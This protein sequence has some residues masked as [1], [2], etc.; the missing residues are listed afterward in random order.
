MVW[1]QWFFRLA[2]DNQGTSR[3]GLPEGARC[4]TASLYR[5]AFL[6]T[7][8]AGQ[9][10]DVVLE[11]IDAEA[12]SR[13]AAIAKA[14]AVIRSDLAWS[15][16]QTETARVEE[17]IPVGGDWRLDDRTTRDNVEKALLGIDLFPRCV[18]VLSV[19]EGIPQGDVAVLLDTGV[20]AVRKG[21]AIGLQQLTANLAR[22]QGWTPHGGILSL[23]REPQYA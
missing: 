20:D 19:F 8:N 10:E 4:Y 21:Q 12:G 14:L 23:N 13:S 2:G 3:T 9:S 7:G 16:R 15:V 6:L 22:N 11:V 5:L 18:V 17:A 1:Q